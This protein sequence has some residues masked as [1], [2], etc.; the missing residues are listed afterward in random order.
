MDSKTI[1][2]ILAMFHKEERLWKI[3]LLENSGGSAREK[4]EEVEAAEEDFRKEIGA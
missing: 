4:L 3:A 1:A 2:L